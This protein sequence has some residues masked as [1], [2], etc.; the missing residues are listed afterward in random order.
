MDAA[1]KLFLLKESDAKIFSKEDDQFKSGTV[2]DQDV[3]CQDC[4][5]QMQ[6]SH[7]RENGLDWACDGCGVVYPCKPGFSFYTCLKC[8]KDWCPNCFHLAGIPIP[9][10]TED[11]VNFI[12]FNASSSVQLFLLA[13]C[14]CL[15]SWFSNGK[16]KRKMIDQTLKKMNEKLDITEIIQNMRSLSQLKRQADLETEEKE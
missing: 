9:K 15:K 5:Q 7:H 8:D 16:K 4:T 13:W 2:Y 10:K 3:S 6:L 11:G 1:H 14:P 12:H